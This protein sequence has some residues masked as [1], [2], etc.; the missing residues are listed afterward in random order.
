[1][2][3]F[4]SETGEE[5]V[6]TAAHVVGGL[7]RGWQPMAPVYTTDQFPP[8][9]AAQAHIGH[10]IKTVPEGA[11]AACAVD[12]AVFRPGEH[13]RCNRD[14]GRGAFIHE[15]RE[16]SDEDIGAVVYKRGCSTGLTQGVFYEIAADVELR[17]RRSP[18]FDV[19]YERVLA[20]LPEPDLPF[21]SPGD[22]G[23]IV[24]DDRRRA[25]GLIVGMEDPAKVAEPLTFCVPMEAV[26]RELGLVI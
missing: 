12:A 22:S 17:I 14:S 3:V 4:D 15:W 24:V 11:E 21:A 20:I 13:V 23:A 1:M 9:P 19:L 6:L 2:P 25:V 26:V 5:L 7:A 16:L 18:R 10:T 8:I